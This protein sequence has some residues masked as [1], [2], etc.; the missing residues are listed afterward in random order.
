MMARYMQAWMDVESAMDDVTMDR[1]M[2]GEPLTLMPL[3]YDDA[4]HASLDGPSQDDSTSGRMWSQ[5]WMT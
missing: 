4:L 3:G 2:D 1:W 5:R